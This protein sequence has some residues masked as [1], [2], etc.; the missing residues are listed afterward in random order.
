MESF[1]SIY[2]KQGGGT[3][4]NLET[5]Q[6]PTGGLSSRRSAHHAAGVAAGNLSAQEAGRGPRQQS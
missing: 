6:A 2:G 3:W 4:T 1:M 5:K